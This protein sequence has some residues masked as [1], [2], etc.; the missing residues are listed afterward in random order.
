MYGTAVY[1]KERALK[2]PKTTMDDR[3][4]RVSL[5]VHPGHGYSCS[6]CGRRFKARREGT[7]HV[8]TCKEAGPA[9]HKIRRGGS[10][11]AHGAGKC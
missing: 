8:A 6:R 2:T 11:R 10:C 7:A 3:Q 4:P 9:K 1:D 5:R